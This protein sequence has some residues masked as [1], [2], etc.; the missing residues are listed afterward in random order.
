MTSRDRLVLA[1]TMSL[2]LA[3]GFLH[4][5]VPRFGLDFDRLHIFLFNLCSG[6]SV[7]L[8]FARGERRVTPLVYA[9]FALTLVYA[10]SAFLEQY[11]ATLV[12]S[13]PLVAIVE[14]VR[15]RRFSFFPR[16]FFRPGPTS[17]KFLHA[18]L[19]CL[20]IGIV[21]ASI[22]MLNTEYVHAFSLRKLTLNVFFLGYSFPISLMTFSVIFS[23]MKPPK[24]LS[25]KVLRE[26]SFWTI[27]LGVITF[28]GFIIFE[29]GG[30]EV[31]VSNTL[32][33]AVVL[34]YAIFRRDTPAV[35][36][37]L[38]LT[39]GMLFLIVTGLTGVFYLFDSFIP[40]SE[41]T[42]RF[43]LVL[44]ATVSLYG[45]NMSGVFIVVRASA[46]PIFKRPV[47]FVLL[48]WLSVFI[49]TPLG[50]YYGPVA[51]VA[52]VAYAVLVGS[53]FFTRS[54]KAAEAG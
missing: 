34:T 13:I 26:V 19:L 24:S 43:I 9:Y 28:F 53:F 2:A 23:F 25:D 45:W 51:L 8:F 42:R 44:H 10:A 32:L 1:V 40:M 46:Y 22:V 29:L 5:L 38:I 15:V 18:A 11:W 50:K 20:S 52:L 48:H 6:G 7:L 54:L 39:S 36:Q 35:Q 47:A 30:A 3:F 17:E 49:L 37:K 12:L 31:V 4:V 27:T 33:A 14:S 16:D 41:E 21:I